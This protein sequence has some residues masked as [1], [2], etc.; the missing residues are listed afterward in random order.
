V[1]DNSILI[2]GG[3]QQIM[4]LEGY[5]IPM[6]VQ[7]GIAIPPNSICTDAECDYFP[8]VLL[9]AETEFHHYVS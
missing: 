7:S 8:N 3:I 1:N 2:A 5:A 6:V 4:A 9:T